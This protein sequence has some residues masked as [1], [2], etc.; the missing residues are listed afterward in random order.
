MVNV[1]GIARLGMLAVGLGV[2]AAWAHTPVASAHSSTDW[3]SSI[4]SF[5]GGGAPLPRHR[6]WIWPSR[7]TGIR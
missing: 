7:S 2:G 3:L 5:V 4:D 6:V 1:G